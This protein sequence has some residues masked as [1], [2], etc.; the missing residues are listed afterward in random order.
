MDVGITWHSDEE[1]AEQ[2]AAGV[3]ERGRNAVVTRF[4][5]TDLDNVAGVVG[6]FGVGLRGIDGFVNK[7]RAGGRRRVVD[8]ARRG[9]GRGTRDPTPTR[10]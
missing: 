8:V 3:R 10:R 1:G 6:G 2:T 7:R 9:G 4:D 5:A